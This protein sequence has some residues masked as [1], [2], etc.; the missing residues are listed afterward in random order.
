MEG[1]I[2]KK[3]IKLKLTLVIVLLVTSGFVSFLYDF[4]T[5]GILCSVFAA[6]ILLSCFTWSSRP[7]GEQSCRAVSCCHYLGD[8]EDK[9]SKKP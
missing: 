7:A 8:Q 1:A 2:N 3:F 9:Q 5:A 4:A 6:V